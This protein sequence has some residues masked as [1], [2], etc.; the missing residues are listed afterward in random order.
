MKLRQQ[1]VKIR[2]SEVLEGN[3]S[4]KTSE[5]LPPPPPR[6]PPKKKDTEEQR[7]EKAFELFA[8]CSNQALNDV[9][10]IYGNMTA[11]KLRNRNDSVRSAFQN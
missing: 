9:C 4:E 10:Q 5:F 7:L 1:K 8:G 2:M 11:A 3:S 6:C